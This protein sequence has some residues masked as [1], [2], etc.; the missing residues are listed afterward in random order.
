MQALVLD[1]RERV[2]SKVRLEDVP[3]M[4]CV[5]SSAASPDA[6]S[7]DSA[8]NSDATLK[9][10]GGGFH[11]GRQAQRWSLGTLWCRCRSTNGTKADR[12]ALKAAGGLGYQNGRR[13]HRWSLG[14][15]WCRCGSADG[16]KADRAALKAAGRGCQCSRRARRRGRPWHRS[17]CRGADGA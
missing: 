10:A 4:Q 11:Y 1:S 9:A 17:E 13:A 5:L 6:R 12:T 2:E 8:R 15:L 3:I 16:T 14:T 7:A